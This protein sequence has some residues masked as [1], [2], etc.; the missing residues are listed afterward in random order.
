MC[1]VTTLLVREYFFFKEQSAQLES[2]KEDYTTYIVAFKKLVYEYGSLKEAQEGET[3][4]LKKKI[5]TSNDHKN[6]QFLVVNREPHYL[7]KSALSFARQHNLTSALERRYQSDTFVVGT[8]AKKKLV[9]KNCKKRPV[10]SYVRRLS[11]YLSAEQRE[12]I[13][14][15]PV[16]K[17]SFWLSSPFGPRRKRSGA[18]GFHKGIDMGASRGTPVCAAG[19][20]IVALACYQPGYGNTILIEHNSKFKTRYA[21]LDK[22]HVE[23][24]DHVMKGQIIG[25]VGETGNVRKSSWARSAAHLHFEV[26]VYNKQVNPFIFL[27]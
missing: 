2:L 24:G 3:Q 11:H 20:G 9:K 26:Y 23:A 17:G 13:F 14:D 22:I 27:V 25:K 8:T 21:H 16:A 7:K 6:G 18:L 15:W 5:I 10:L 1:I 4:E 12:P 19:G